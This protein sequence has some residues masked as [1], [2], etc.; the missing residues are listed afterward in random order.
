MDRDDV[1]KEVWSVSCDTCGTPAERAETWVQ[2]L[3]QAVRAGWSM[4]IKFRCPKCR[5]KCR[6]K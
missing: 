1:I 3:R 4:M 5:Q 2:S 6:P